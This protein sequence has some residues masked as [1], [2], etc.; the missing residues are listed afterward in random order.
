MLINCRVFLSV[1]MVIGC[2]TSL[3]ADQHQDKKQD[4]PI[5]HDQHQKVAQKPAASHEPH[6][7]PKIPATPRTPSLSRSSE[8]PK[9]QS[10]PHHEEFKQQVK[11]VEHHKKKPEELKSTAH[12]NVHHRNQSQDVAKRIKNNHPHHHQ[13]FNDNYFQQHNYHPQYEHGHANWWHG[14]HWNR[15]H[16]WLGWGDSVYPIYYDDFGVPLQIDVDPY[17]QED[18]IDVIATDWLPLGVFALGSNSSLAAYS[19]IFLQLAVNQKG[20]I[21]GTYY[22]A[23]TD[24]N[25]ALEGLIE[26]ASQTAYWKIV[27]DPQSP[28]MST[29]VYNLTQDVAPL[30]MRF[31][32]EVIQNWVLIRVEE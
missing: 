15:V 21:A 7:H 14:A 20:D 30:Q 13:W 10:H 4:Q 5:H 18:D 25:Y 16:H 17:D 1:L 28:M 26:P 6:S 27:E 19:N 32:G 12:P 2:E 24:Q 23:A 3:H 9:P 11:K 29:G 22:N 8:K 31:P